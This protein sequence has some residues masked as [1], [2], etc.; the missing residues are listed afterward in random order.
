MT[1]QQQFFP[2]RG[3]LDQETPAIAMPPGRAISVVNYESTPLG[4][5]RTEGYERFDG[6][7]S[8]SAATFYTL[9]FTAGQTAFTEGLT[10]TGYTSGATARVIAAAVLDSGTFGGGDAVGTLAVH[11]ITGEFDSGELLRI[12]ATTYAMLNDEPLQSDW[13]A[14]TNERAWFLAAVEHVRGLITAVPGSGPVRG[15]LWFA[16]KLN[17]WRDNAGATAAAIHESSSSGWQA[18]DL[19]QTVA[20]TAGGAYEIQPGD[21]LTGDESGATAT[22]RYVALDSGDWATS[23]AA[24][25]LVLDDVTGALGDETFTIGVNAATATVGASPAAQVLAPGGSYKFDIFNFFATEGSERAYGVSGVAQAFEF[26]GASVTPITTGMESTGS[27]PFLI[28][29]HKNHLFVA[30]PF[31]SLQHSRLGEPRD[32]SGRLGAAELG[33]G[34]EITN[35]IPNASAT[36]LITT[37]QTLAVLTGNDSSDWVLEPLSED[38]GA[39]L[40]TARRI[41]DVIY[42]DNRGVRSVTS[43]QTFGN[44]RIGTYTRLINKTLKAKRDHGI[45]PVG[46]CVIKGKDQYLLFFDDGTGISIYFG[47]KQPEP[48]LFEYPFTVSCVH[49]AEVDGIERVFVGATDG[50]AYE[51]NVGT[52]FDGAEI[53]AFLQLPFGHQGDPRQFKRYSKLEAEVLA[54]QGTELGLVTQFDYGNDYQPLASEDVFDVIGG[55]GGLWGVAVWGE[56]AWSAPQVGKAELWIDGSGVN[57]SPIFVSRQNIVP[58]HT[59]AGVTV[60]FNPRGHKR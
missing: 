47:Q 48:M 11:L 12:G 51:L 15:I 16:G 31:G 56:F 50:F 32:F 20:F 60:V 58:S 52:S 13:R 6:Q 57:M 55:S 4:Y 21:T 29:V 28:D 45:E 17:A 26:D 5:Q 34:H 39:K 10:I 46:S 53:E 27:S 41:G 43:T 8:P 9:T 30:F 25:L 42:L 24:G 14:G 23:D 59:I 37:S 49:V 35:L 22:V 38:A 18:L 3:G 33:M 19:G 44:F 1:G 2:L 40:D 7:A 36:L 54:E